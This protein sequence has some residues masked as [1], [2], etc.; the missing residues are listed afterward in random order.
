V[1]L[2]W[3]GLA[4][5]GVV[6]ELHIGEG[7]AAT[8]PGSLRWPWHQPRRA[9]GR[10]HS[11]SHPHL[12]SP[13][14]LLIC[15]RNGLL[16]MASF[17]QGLPCCSGTESG[18]APSA[19]SACRATAAPS[20]GDGVARAPAQKPEFSVAAWLRLCEE[21]EDASPI[22][23]SFFLFVWDFCSRATL[24]CSLHRQALGSGCPLRAGGCSHPQ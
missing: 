12:G 8:C 19:G 23:F 6:W 20:A 10:R 13:S 16:L 21:T 22:P 3:D 1:G 24:P 4:N 15:L 2:R 17:K 11:A 18:L 7:A 9:E 5:A 14:F